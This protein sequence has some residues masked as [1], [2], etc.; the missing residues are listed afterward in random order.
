MFLKEAF[1]LGKA[2]DRFLRSGIDLAPL[3]V[4]RGDN[5]PYFCTPRGASIIGWEG[6]DGVHY[7]FVRGYGET[8]FA[9]NPSNAAPDF[10][11]AVARDFD[12]FL[13]LLLATGGAAIIEQCRH[14]PRE[15]FH[16]TIA[17]ARFEGDVLAA[18]ETIRQKLGLTPMP[19]PWDY[20]HELQDGFDYGKIKYTDPD[21]IPD[22]EPIREEWAVRFGPHSKPGRELRLDARFHWAGREW[23]VPSVYVCAQGLVLDM[24]MRIEPG[25]VR[26]FYGEW[27]AE[28]RD[29]SPVEQRRIEAENPFGFD[30]SAKA[31]LN[32]KRLPMKQSG[33]VGWVPGH[34]DD[35]GFARGFVEHYGLD[36]SYGWSF[37]RHHFAWATR[38][39][40]ERMDSLTLTLDDI[41]AG[42][43]GEPF[44]VS[45]AGD[46]LALTNPETGTEH[47][48][49]VLEY[50]PEMQETDDE[51]F[52][53]PAHRVSMRFTLEPDCGI[54]LMDTEA[55]DPPRP[56]HASTGGV[57]RSYV[58]MLRPGPGGSKTAIS[59][60]RFEPAEHV[61][62]LPVFK[63]KRYE[64]IT[65]TLI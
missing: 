10:V 37:S 17:G 42:V 20:I 47:T 25:D 28:E 26:A 62:W 38:R 53:Y 58:Y 65:V 39:A 34:D 9:V 18:Q 36:A 55:G 29:F 60:A 30:F 50:T 3:G 6:V 57:S 46:T 56:K 40:P 35:P 22:T 7:C 49:T 11:C 63:I 24:C 31:A 15:A 4:A 23:L 33:R 5:D 59:S 1:P 48:L 52:E 41:P 54:E 45:A 61:S 44:T 16:D 43:P 27:G 8:V 64:P 14:W 21:C 2:Y 19:E 12:D 51:D 13:R 32:G